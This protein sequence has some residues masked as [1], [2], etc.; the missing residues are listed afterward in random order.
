VR[1]EVIAF[2]DKIYRFTS[3]QYLSSI[4]WELIQS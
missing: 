3:S 2:I 4:I 1:S